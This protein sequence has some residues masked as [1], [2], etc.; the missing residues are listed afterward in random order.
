MCIQCTETILK[1]TCTIHKQAQETPQHPKH[2]QKHE[3]PYIRP[4][5]SKTAFPTVT[6][7]G[8]KFEFQISKMVVYTSIAPK[9]HSTQLVSYTNKHRK[10]N[11]TPNI[12]KHTKT[13]YIRPEMSK[14][15][16][17]HI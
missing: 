10:H 9:L 5:T 11:N 17:G 15:V 14:T 12:V 16:R 7:L 2:S 1:T 3:N 4:E 6:K 8:A 13:A